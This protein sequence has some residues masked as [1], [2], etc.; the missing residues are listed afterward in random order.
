MKH[1]SGFSLPEAMVALIILSFILLPVGQF[2]S[3]LVRSYDSSHKHIELQRQFRETAN[4]I[5]AIEADATAST[6]RLRLV[7]DG[8]DIGPLAKSR[9]T[10]SANCSYDLVGRRCR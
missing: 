9:I 6:T 10:Q 4:G 8:S 5:S 3:V 7:L 2:V 1:Q